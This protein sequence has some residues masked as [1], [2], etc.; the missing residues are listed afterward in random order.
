MC[1]CVHVCMTIQ[2]MTKCSKLCYK[3]FQKFSTC[4]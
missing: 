2:I 1:V 3:H 4:A